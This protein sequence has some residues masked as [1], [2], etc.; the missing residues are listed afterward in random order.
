MN[1]VLGSRRD[2][3]TEQ[4]ET[5]GNSCPHRA[6]TSELSNH[7]LVLLQGIQ[8]DF[9]SRVHLPAPLG[10]HGVGVMSLGGHIQNTGKEEC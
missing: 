3:Y 5:G 1:G 4:D 6:Q 2:G 8:Q 10:A 9:L 7:V